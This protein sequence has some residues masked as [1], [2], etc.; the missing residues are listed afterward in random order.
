MDKL[1]LDQHISQKYNNELEDIRNRALA[2][3]GLVEK[4]VAGGLQALLEGDSALGESIALADHE[5]NS[6]EVEIDEECLQVLARRQP[7]ASDL[8]LLVTVIK[9]ITDLERIGDEA[10]KLGRLSVKL[11]NSEQ[12][13]AY[14]KELRHIGGLVVSLLRDALDSFARLDV[15]A[16]I[17]TAARDTDIDSEYDTLSRLL[18]TRIMEDPREVKNVLRI[19]WCARALERIGDHSVNICEYVVYLVRGRDIRH[20]KFDQVQQ[21]FLNEQ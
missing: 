16:A 19:A 18:I 14:H 3:G 7:A 21:E 1:H 17:R 8:R 11:S 13:P 4:L 5:V 20:L 15:E 9:I 2:M 6:M 12:L 10:E